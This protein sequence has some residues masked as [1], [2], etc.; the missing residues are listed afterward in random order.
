MSVN[1]L[2]EKVLIN[3]LRHTKSRLTVVSCEAKDEA[4]SS[5]P[6]Y[7]RLTRVSIIQEQEL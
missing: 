7:S 6:T 3:L 1:K 4:A 5:A 2:V